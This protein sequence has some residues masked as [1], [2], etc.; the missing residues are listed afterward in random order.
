MS[1]AD[2]R[3]RAPRRHCILG[4]ERDAADLRH[5]ARDHTLRPTAGVADPVSERITRSERVE[6][7]KGGKLAAADRGAQ[8][9]LG[10]TS[11]T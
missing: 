1:V 2:S 8:C 6:V 10:A 11:L 3:Q 9:G 5:E 4:R 7:R